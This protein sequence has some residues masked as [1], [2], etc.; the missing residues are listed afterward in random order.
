MKWLAYGWL[1]AQLA[2]SPSLTVDD[3][4]SGDEDGYFGLG[5]NLTLVAR[6][7]TDVAAWLDAH[8]GQRVV[9]V[10]KARRNE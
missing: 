6:P 7:E 2:G 4:L 1:V 10:L 3:K 8:S 5:P 9:L